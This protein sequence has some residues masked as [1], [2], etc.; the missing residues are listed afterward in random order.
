MV[1]SLERGQF[2][3]T[4]VWEELP[5]LQRLVELADE[6]EAGPELA[7]PEPAVGPEPAENLPTS[8]EPSRA[9]LSEGPELVGMTTVLATEGSGTET[10]PAPERTPS[11]SL[12]RLTIVPA[13]PVEP[14]RTLAALLARMWLVRSTVS[15]RAPEAPPAPTSPDASA[16]PP[17]VP[18]PPVPAAPARVGPVAPSALPPPPPPQVALAPRTP[19]PIVARTT[20]RLPDE[21]D[22]RPLSGLASFLVE[23]AS[24]LNRPAPP[25]PTTPRRSDDRVRVVYRI[26]H[27][28][29]PMPEQPVSRDACRLWRVGRDS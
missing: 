12:P 15:T 10:P 5:P 20:L 17:A 21:D 28:Q 4:A 16:A 19:S 29:H 1:R 18:S 25:A 13:D 7:L 22:R 8:V 26:V 9:D 14:S 23:V 3:A 6:G 27:C 11:V 2:H 24:N